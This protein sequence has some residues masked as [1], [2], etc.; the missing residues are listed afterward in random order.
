MAD[1]SRQMDLKSFLKTIFFRIFVLW[2]KKKMNIK[3]NHLC[4][5]NAEKKDCEQ[6]AAWWNDGTVMAHAGFPNGLGTSAAE[7][8]KQNCRRQR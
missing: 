2:R 1:F 4:I 5:R 3:Y 6:L 8:E 7:I